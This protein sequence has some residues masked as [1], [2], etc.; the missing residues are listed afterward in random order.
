MGFPSDG[1]TR[2]IVALAAARLFL[3]YLHSREGQQVLTDI[4]GLR[5]F[6]P[7]AKYQEGLMPLSAIK[8]MKA[9]PVEQVEMEGEIKKEYAEF[10]AV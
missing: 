9:D 2:Q 8:V 10:S 1:S 7:D 4:A 6:D 3:S 5:S